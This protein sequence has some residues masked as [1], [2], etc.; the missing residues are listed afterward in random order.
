MKAQCPEC[1]WS[2]DVPES[3]QGRKV[4]CPECSKVFGIR[5]GGESQDTGSPLWLVLFLTVTPAAVLLTAFVTYIVRPVSPEKLKNRLAQVEKKAA[6]YKSKLEGAEDQLAKKE[7]QLQRVRGQNRKLS[8]QDE[9]QPDTSQEQE[10]VQKKK[11]EKK[12]KP[13]K[14]S[15]PEGPTDFRN[16]RWGMSPDEVQRVESANLYG[17]PGK[18]PLLFEDT[19]AG[20]NMV[21][22]YIFVDQKLVRAKYILNEKHANRNAYISDFRNLGNMLR[23]KYGSADKNEKVWS[24]DLYRDDPSEWGMA[25]AVGHLMMVKKWDIPRTGLTAIIYGDNY[26]ITVAIEYKSKKLKHLEK[27]QKEEGAMENL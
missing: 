27:K 25:I 20:Y 9:K 26:D 14:K 10:D 2:K 18:N 11:N 17:E 6:D 22:V 12:H 23:K 21:V 7:E 15:Q 8:S 5:G 3:A 1:G 4:K 24:K 16:T 13:E 19:V